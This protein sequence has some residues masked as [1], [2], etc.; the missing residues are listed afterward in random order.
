MSTEVKE[1]FL[2]TT[3]AYFVFTST[4]DVNPITLFCAVFQDFS[5]VS[6]GESSGNLES[7]QKEINKCKV[8]KGLEDGHLLT[9][10]QAII[11]DALCPQT[12]HDTLI[13]DKKMFK[14]AIESNKNF[15]KQFQERKEEKKLSIKEDHKKCAEKIQKEK[16]G[17]SKYTENHHIYFVFITTKKL[18]ITSS[19]INVFFIN[20]LTSMQEKRSIIQNEQERL[21]AEILQIKEELQFLDEKNESLRQQTEVCRSIN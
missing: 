14:D 5:L 19:F 7:I 12:Q 8:C 2:P 17:L 21:K 3:K 6:N 20:G 10:T 18:V 13:K 15:A 1:M 16:V 11:Y 9:W 4:I